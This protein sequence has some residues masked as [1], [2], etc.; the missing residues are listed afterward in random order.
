MLVSKAIIPAA[1]LGTRF[2]P[3][4]KVIPKE[5]LPLI[6]KPSIQYV[7]EEGIKSGIK[8]FI[9]ISGRGKEA[10]SNHFST[11]EELDL[12]LQERKKDDLLGNISKIISLANFMYV[13]QHQQLGLG[14]A[15]WTARHAIGKEYV[16]VMLPDDIFMGTTPGLAQLI[17][18]AT[19]EKCSVIAV[20]EVSSAETSR[21]GVIDVKKQFSPNLFQIRDLI[22]K[23]TKNK[24]PSNLAIVGRYVLAPE[25]FEALE[26]T[27]SGTGGEIQLTDGIQKMLLMGEKIF[28]Y[29]IKGE[30]YDAGTPIGLLKSSIALA[31]KNPAYSSEM[32]EFLSELDRD[33]VVMQGKAAVLQ[34][35][36]GL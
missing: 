12:K 31:L 9:M 5:M 22:E 23:P 1:G 25:V 6:D 20:K 17:K 19:Q 36:G 21:Y 3:A 30:H 2:L 15:I 24:A 34:K 8:S 14:H 18:V 7:V 32:I 26:E 4:T 16:S 28:A 13:P 11:N 33:L 35:Q 27:G 10:I 29:K